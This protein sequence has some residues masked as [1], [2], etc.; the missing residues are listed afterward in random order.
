LLGKLMILWGGRT[1]SSLSLCR[2]AGL[3]YG[4]WAPG[5]AGKFSMVWRDPGPSQ[6][7]RRGAKGEG[8]QVLPSPVWFEPLRPASVWLLF[9]GLKVPLS[10]SF[11]PQAVNRRRAEGKPSS[12]RTMLTL[13]WLRSQRAGEDGAEFVRGQGKR[14][15]LHAAGLGGGGGEGGHIGGLQT[16][17]REVWNLQLRGEFA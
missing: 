9:K 13:T 6:G 8:Y 16:P 3:R 15:G 2:C 10:N 1:K 11:D 12:N 14:I 17:G 7:S 4:V 5:D